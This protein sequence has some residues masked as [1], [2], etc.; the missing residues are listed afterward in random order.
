MRCG[1]RKSRPDPRDLVYRSRRAGLLNLPPPP[2]I[3]RSG[4]MPVVWD[5][6]DLGSCEAHAGAAKL[7]ELFPGFIGS[8]LAIYYR[9]RQLEHDVKS[10]DGM[11][12]RDLMKVLQA[13]TIAETLW[14]YD[15]A[16]FA[17]APPAS[18]EMRLVGSYSRITSKRDLIDHLAHDGAVVL[19]FG[20]PSTFMDNGT[21]P[22]TADTSE[23]WHCVLAVG[24]DLARDALF[25]RN[26]WGPGWGTHGY[27]WM[28]I[29]WAVSD[30]TGGDMWAAHAADASTVA[31]VTLQGATQ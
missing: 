8:R 19:S 26:S 28:P 29:A 1:S 2:R 6:G 9:G 5:Q 22:A 30:E 20:V 7:Y 24:Y 11:E 21:F 18:S 12:T 27:F 4:A 3:D 16:K 10:D 23:G 13:G 14:P 15:V 17:D 25:V 31:G